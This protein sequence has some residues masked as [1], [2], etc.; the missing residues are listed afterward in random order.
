[1]GNPGG[2]RQRACRKN[3]KEAGVMKEVSV[4]LP[5]SISEKL[6]GQP[7]KLSEFFVEAE[8][9]FA[10]EIKAFKAELNR[11]TAQ[12][13]LIG[14]NPTKEELLA[15][16]RAL[17]ISTTFDPVKTRTAITDDIPDLK[18]RRDEL[19]DVVRRKTGQWHWLEEEILENRREADGW[20]GILGTIQAALSGNNSPQ[21]ASILNDIETAKSKLRNVV[22]SNRR[23][24][25][26]FIDAVLSRRRKRRKAR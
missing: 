14:P 11:P 2:K 21:A 5:D 6:E 13:W 10:R 17:G 20:I 15:Q 16:C 24:S 9:R 8:L 7:K 12:Q 4:F 25:A 26:P 23:I 1:M 22:E 18:E 19:K 3:V